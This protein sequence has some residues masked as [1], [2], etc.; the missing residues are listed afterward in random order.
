MYLIIFIFSI[1]IILILLALWNYLLRN[2]TDTVNMDMVS[3]AKKSGFIP[4]PHNRKKCQ[5]LVLSCQN[6]KKYRIAIVCLSVG[7]RKFAQISREF[8]TKYCNKHGYDLHYFT[9]ILDPNY[10]VIWQ[11]IL[12]FRKVFMMDTGSDKT[13]PACTSKQA[14][15]DYIMWID[16]DI[17]IK[18]MNIKVEDFIALSDKPIIASQDVFTQYYDIHI[19]AGT[20]IF[21]NCKIA[22]EVIDA[23]VEGYH[24]V[25]DGRF[26]TAPYHDQ[27]VLVY[28]YFTKYH[29]SIE[30]LPHGIM[31]TIYGRYESWE[32]E[33][34]THLA[35]VKISKRNKIAEEYKY[36]LCE[37]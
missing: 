6:T 30:V 24:N 7:S 2:N 21:K 28:L 35:G 10:T 13:S 15:Y 16:D 36:K 3:V 32:G 14:K 33:F 25:F 23:W 34:A 27:N 11:K 17:I 31:Q 20:F 29:P 8:L 19:N 18:N 26:Q 22:R 12:A 4:Y 37:D 9:E 5:E 1:I